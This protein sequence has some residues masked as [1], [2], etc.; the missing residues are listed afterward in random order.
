ML[1]VAKTET[2]LFLSFLPALFQQG[3]QASVMMVADLSSEASRVKA[4][5]RLS[6]F[7]GAGALIGPILGGYTSKNFSDRTTVILSSII[8]GIFAL[9]LLLNNTSHNS[10]KKSLERKS[11]FSASE[12][13]RLA[14]YP[15]V[16]G[17]LLLCLVYSFSGAMLSS[18]LSEFLRA[19]FNMPVETTGLVLSY[20]EFI[21][22]ISQGLVVGAMC[23]YLTE[24]HAMMACLLV[25]VA[26]FAGLVFASDATHVVVLL[27]PLTVSGMTGT[28]ISGMLTRLVPHDDTGGVIGLNMAMMSLAWIFA[29]I[30]A[31]HLNATGGFK[32]VC[33]A[34]CVAAVGACAVA[35]LTFA[36]DADCQHSASYSIIPDGKSVVAPLPEGSSAT[37]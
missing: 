1:G 33:G 18:M 19:D 22:M 17:L 9:M 32:M 16:A 35:R 2:V 34:S 3:F 27:L 31:E 21:R 12:V 20:I 25:S 24:Q 37:N 6:L 11:V 14:R 36:A 5:G 23:D 29:P 7:Y 15:R 26:S 28:I 4:I 8:S 13:V 10:K 30:A